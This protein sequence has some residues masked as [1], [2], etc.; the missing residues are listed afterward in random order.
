MTTDLEAVQHVLDQ[1]GDTSAATFIYLL[2]E[3][4]FEIVS[5]DYVRDVL[6]DRASEDEHIRKIIKEELLKHRVLVE[7]H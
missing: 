1:S 6:G 7:G 3:I 5:I 2:R 4:G